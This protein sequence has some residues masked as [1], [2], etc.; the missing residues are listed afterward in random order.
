MGKNAVVHIKMTPG[1]KRELRIAAAH[2]EISM[3]E[4]IRRAVVARTANNKQKE[5]A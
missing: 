4:F 3:G 2:E 1:E 5:T